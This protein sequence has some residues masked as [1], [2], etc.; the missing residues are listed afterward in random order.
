MST[1]LTKEQLRTLGMDTMSA[2]QREDFLMDVGKTVFDNAI[3]KL[4]ET[5]T[6]DQIHALNHALEDNES[7]EAVV[8]YLQVTYPRF[9]NYIQEVQEHFVQE[10]M[11]NM[12][13]TA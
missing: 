2:P 3:V 4:L 8:Q 6:D 12:R 13:Q 11:Q 5:L 10:V 9:V 1:Q 7:L